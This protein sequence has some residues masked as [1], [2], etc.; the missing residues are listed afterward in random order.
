MTTWIADRSAGIAGMH[1]SDVQKV[2]GATKTYSS[3][4]RS[5]KPPDVQNGVGQ[6]TASIITDDPVAADSVYAYLRPVPGIQVLPPE[7]AGEADVVVVVTTTPTEELLGTL[8][9]VHRSAVNPRQCM[10]LISNPLP[11]R[12]LARAFRD[13][14]VSVV[15]RRTATREAVIHAVQA[16]GHGSSVL[17]GPTARWLADHGRNFEQV[18]LSAHGITAGGLTTREVD[19]LKLLA[20]GMS[21]A[22]IARHLNYAE[23]TIKNVIADMLS[24]LGLRNR[25]QAVAHAYRVGAI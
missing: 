22:E 13:G 20:D 11:E 24:R 5:R 8:D 23:R 7:G 12:H 1:M 19:I 25:T 15:P 17:A 14:V 2:N 4:S 3:N 16:S 21:T 9:E 18:L 6:L 10:V